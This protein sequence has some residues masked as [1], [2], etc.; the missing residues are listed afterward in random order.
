MAFD[1]S[2]LRGRIVEKFGTLGAFSDAMNIN[3]STIAT[4]FNGESAWRQDDI[5]KACELLGIETADIPAYFF[6]EEVVKSSTKR[7]EK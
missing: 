5:I 4:R 3:R 1:Y 6:A 7:S 2:K